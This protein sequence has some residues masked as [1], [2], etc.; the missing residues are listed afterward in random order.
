[1]ALKRRD[2]TLSGLQLTAVVQERIINI[3]LRDYWY[4]SRVITTITLT[5]YTIV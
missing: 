1:L 5:L 4:R 2:R 3:R